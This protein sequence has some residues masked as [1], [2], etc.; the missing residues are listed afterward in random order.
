MNKQKT[1]TNS[2]LT[3][4]I[5]GLFLPIFSLSIFWL[6]KYSDLK[7][8]EF[9]NFFFDLKILTHLISLCALPNLLIFFIFMWRN[10][11]LSA[12]GVIMATFFIVAIVL[13]VRFL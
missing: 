13:I 1:R 7:L 12:R 11:L 4:L 2:L 6:V 3:G 9:L 5:S 8:G 10:L